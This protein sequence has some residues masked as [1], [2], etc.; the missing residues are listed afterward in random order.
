MFI[1]ISQNLVNTPLNLSAS[2][3]KTFSCVF[4]QRVSYFKPDRFKIASALEHIGN[5]LINSVPVTKQ[6][7]ENDEGYQ[8]HYD[9]ETFSLF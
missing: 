8:K 5:K 1:R 3:R 9:L 2:R 4:I 7:C 6:E